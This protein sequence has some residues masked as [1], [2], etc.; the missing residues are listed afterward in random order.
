MMPHLRTPRRP[1]RASALTLSLALAGAAACSDRPTAPPT[2]PPTATPSPS[3]GRAALPGADL[4]RG[5]LH[6][7]SVRDLGTLPAPNDYA[8]EAWRVN[9]RGQVVGKS[10]RRGDP[11]S[12]GNYWSPG[13][14]HDVVWQPDGTT[15]DVTAR[16][17]LYFKIASAITNAGTVLL[18]DSDGAPSVLW[19]GS[20]TYVPSPPC[21]YPIATDVNESGLVSASLTCFAD[22]NATAAAW[23][24]GSGWS[25]PLAPWIPGSFDFPPGA[26]A[27][28]DFGDL[29]GSSPDRGAG[30]SL[31]PT[32]WLRGSFTRVVLDCRPECAR[33]AAR[34]VNERRWIVGTAFRGP[35]L[36]AGAWALLWTPTGGTERIPPLPGH[37]Q[38]AAFGVNERN[39]VVGFSWGGS[40]L[41]RAFVWTRRDGT[42]P[43]G[44][45]PGA[46]ASRA[47]G[48]ND[49]GQ[50][51]GSSGLYVGHH[52][53]NASPDFTRATLWQIDA[54]LAS[55]LTD[56]T[57]LSLT[58]TA[59][60]RL[61][62]LGAQAFEPTQ[63]D[64]GS[65][66]LGDEVGQD[67]PPALDAK[68]VPVTY[69]KDVN[70]DGRLDLAIEFPIPA[71]VKNGDLRKET[72]ELRLT[73]ALLQGRSFDGTIR[74]TTAP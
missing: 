61:Y 23:Q 70:G 32:L 41:P 59:N 10:G 48:I 40:L 31:Q 12:F 55:I 36:L 8:S 58:S 44:E 46:G 25:S 4:R 64:P 2:A 1:A 16:T 5:R 63:V 72:T 11:W 37:D 9:E 13:I 45:L 38:A 7:L 19:N 3:A 24:A 35:E 20:A 73:G 52:P 33:G 29:V 21:G 69:A 62:L 43:L 27:A 67:T 66:R 39:Q 65:L 14:A 57:S 68:G 54:W 50:I 56:Q 30:T 74:V 34:D 42:Q 18:T 53:T 15:V 17:G 6:V 28:N 47:F 49:R 22:G 26:M 71:L 51:V 60:A